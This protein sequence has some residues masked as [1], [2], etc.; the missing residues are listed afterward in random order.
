MSTFIHKID[1]PTF[2]SQSRGS[3]HCS[4][5]TRTEVTGEVRPITDE[6]KKAILLPTKT[7]LNKPFLCSMMAYKHAKSKTLP[8]NLK[9]WFWPGS[10]LVWSVMIDPERPEA[11]EAVRVAKEAVQSWSRVTTKAT[12]EAIAKRL[13]IIDPNDTAITSLQELSWMNSSDE[14]FQK[15]FKQYS[16]CFVYHLNTRFGRVP[17]AKRR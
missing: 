3:N 1:G 6:D 14:E 11:A 4:N 2:I 17:L 7:W 9:R 12:A 8:W 13:G 16:V 15:V 5:V 10:S